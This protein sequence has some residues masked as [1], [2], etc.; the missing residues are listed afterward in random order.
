MQRPEYQA[1]NEIIWLVMYRLAKVFFAFE[2]HVPEPEPAPQV[3]FRQLINMNTNQIFRF[4]KN[5]KFGEKNNKI[6]L[7]KD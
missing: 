1:K 2:G 5:I 6:S 3:Q 7:Q 4:I